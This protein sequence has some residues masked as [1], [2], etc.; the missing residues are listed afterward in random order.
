MFFTAQAYRADTLALPEL[1][2]PDFLMRKH[3]IS[4]PK[5]YLA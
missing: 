5:P 1:S 2:P 3:C 4:S